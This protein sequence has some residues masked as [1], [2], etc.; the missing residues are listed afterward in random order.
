MIRERCPALGSWVTGSTEPTQAPRRSRW[1][2]QTLA[3]VYGGVCVLRQSLSLSFAGK[4]FHTVESSKALRRDLGQC[5]ARMARGLCRIPAFRRQPQA[6]VGS[7]ARRRSAPLID[8]VPA[9]D[10][11]G[12]RRSRSFQK[13]TR[14]PV[15]SGSCRNS[16]FH[17]DLNPHNIVVNS[18]QNSAR[19]RRDYRPSATLPQPP[20]SS[21]SPVTAAYQV[22]D[23]DDPLAPACDMIAAY[24]GESRR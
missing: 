2:W 20:G 13:R 3:T 14:L 21:T 12:E 10:S 1:D 23:S 22:T 11:A 18:S 17:N 7:P 4:P 24:H 15:L 9:G 5:A 16:R 8:A 19:D 6:A